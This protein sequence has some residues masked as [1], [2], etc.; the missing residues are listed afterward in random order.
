L[1]PSRAEQQPIEGNQAINEER[2]SGDQQSFKKR[3]QQQTYPDEM[4]VF[5]GNLPPNIE[6]AELQQFF[7]KFG[8]ILDVRI[9]RTNQKAGS[10][11]TPNYGF[12]TFD[13]P[14]IVKS[15]LGQKPIYFNEHRFNVEVKRS[16]QRTGG[17]HRSGSGAGQGGFSGR[18]N[19]PGGGGGVGGGPITGGTGGSQ[20][21]GQ[22]SGRDGPRRGGDDSRPFRKSAPRIRK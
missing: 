16:P 22:Y 5:V 18:P 15:I 1:T 13:D 14:E 2:S 17:I 19:Q 7:S 8:K 21:G 11:K 4:Q 3:E 10:V 12:V 20:G 9:N 6:E